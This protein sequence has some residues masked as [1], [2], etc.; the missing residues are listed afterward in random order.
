MGRLFRCAGESRSG[1]DVWGGD[2][3]F[4]RVAGEMPAT[5]HLLELFR[6]STPDKATRQ[7]ILVDNPV[8]LYGFPN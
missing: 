3:P 5:G 4:P 6:A 7:R 1:T 8:R 2:W